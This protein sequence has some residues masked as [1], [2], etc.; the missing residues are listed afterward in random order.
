MPWD[1][2]VIVTK[3]NE[4][5]ACYVESGFYSI[6]ELQAMINSMDAY[7][8]EMT[9]IAEQLKKDISHGRTESSGCGID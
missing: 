2:S 8:G 6:E 1:I 4:C 3:Q 5:L 9:K 7:W